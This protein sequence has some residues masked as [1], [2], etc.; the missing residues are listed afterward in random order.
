MTSEFSILTPNAILG[1]GYRAEHFWYGIE[2]VLAQGHHR[3]QWFDG[4]RALQAW[5]E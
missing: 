2:K 3:R 4:R 1:Y 5:L